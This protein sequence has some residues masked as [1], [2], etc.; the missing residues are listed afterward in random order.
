MC[1]IRDAGKVQV[2]V[3]AFAVLA[4][5]NLAFELWLRQEAPEQLK[6][7][8]RLR[9]PSRSTLADTYLQPPH[10]NPTT[11]CWHRRVSTIWFGDWT[12]ALGSDGQ[13]I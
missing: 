9:P 10:W 5:L 13:L 3:T 11:F 6:R 8:R 1:K 4:A 12:Q 2:P 7:A